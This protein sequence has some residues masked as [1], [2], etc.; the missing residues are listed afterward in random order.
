MPSEM[1]MLN[2]LMHRYKMGQILPRMIWLD[3]ALLDQYEVVFPLLK[4]Y[5]IKKGIVIA[6]PTSFVG[7]TFPWTDP[8]V[9]LPMMNI[10][11][12]KEMMNYG[13]HIASHSVTHSHFKKLTNEE[14]RWELKESKK[15]IQDNL[16]VKSSFFVSPYDEYTSDQLEVIKNFYIFARPAYANVFHI[17]AHFM[18]DDP[19]HKLSKRWGDI[20]LFR[21]RI[22]EE[23]RI[24]RIARK[25]LN[26]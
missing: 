20:S 10:K 17:V 12:L 19:E 21:K 8:V 16:G 13:C 22:E 18:R 4:K 6:V 23:L 24:E 1:D 14:F 7:K 15:W 11:Q 5:K 9:D 2:K 3:D 25:I 26:K